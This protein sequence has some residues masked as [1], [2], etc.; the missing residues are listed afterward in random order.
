MTENKSPDLT[1]AAD[2]AFTNNGMPHGFTSLTPFLSIPGAKDALAFY[3]EVF[4]ARPSGVTEF[5]GVVVHAE[6]DFGQGRLQ[7]GEPN[8]SYHLVPAPDGDDDCYSMGFYCPDVD[9]LVQR[10]EQAGAVIREP[11][12]SFVSGDRYASIRDPFGVRWSIMT[13]VQDLSEAESAQRV[14]EWAATNM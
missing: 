8:P 5:D 14:A 1:A 6:L 10:A 11:V 12:T 13:R 2:G 3:E 7:I 4:G 9:S